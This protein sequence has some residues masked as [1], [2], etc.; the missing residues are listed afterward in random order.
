MHHDFGAV[1]V[2]EEAG[3]EHATKTAVSEPFVSTVDVPFGSS[4]FRQ[5]QHR[6]NFAQENP[7]NGLS[8]RQDGEEFHQRE[9]HGDQEYVGTDERQAP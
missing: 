8:R 5:W 2:R 9:H 3:G 6:S 7:E 1:H 4:R